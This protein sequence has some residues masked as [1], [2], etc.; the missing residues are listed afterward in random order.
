MVLENLPYFMNLN[1]YVRAGILFFILFF[2]LRIILYFVEKVLIKLTAKTSTD[3]DDLLLKK[4]SKPLTFIALLISLIFA[5]KEIVWTVNVDVVVYRVLYSLLAVSVGYLIFIVIDVALIRVWKKFAEK[6]E[7]DIDDTIG[8]LVHEILRIVLIVMIVILILNIWGINIGPLLAGLGIA[9]LAVA[10]ALQPTLSNIFSGIAIVLDGTFKVGDVIKVGDKMGEVYKIGLRTTRIKSFDNEMII[11][12]N[13]KIANS[14]VQNFF[15]PDVSIRVNVEFGVE[16]GVDPEY[17]KKIAIEEIE[18]IDFIN[19]E[20]EIRIL[21]TEM[22]NSAL[23]FKAMFWVDDIAKK[24]PAHQEAISRIYRRLY[25]E[26]IGI[27]FPQRTVWMREEG[28]IKSPSPDDSKFKKVKGK[29]FS[30]FGHEYKEEEKEEGE[31][32]KK[33]KWERR[34]NK[35]NFLMSWG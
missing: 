18:K 21:F 35:N 9:G 30:A 27:P 19:K 32:E 34:K 26:K 3:L 15:Q 11:M 2:V 1:S 22:A 12:P 23:N 14:E 25:K 10:L 28:K 24:W 4:S 5:L 29:Y 7:S 13:S 8:Q 20:E 16:Y 31:G 17:I 6:T 33:G